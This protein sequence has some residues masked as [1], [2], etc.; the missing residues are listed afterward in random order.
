MRWLG[1]DDSRFIRATEGI[2]LLI[3]ESDLDKARAAAAV[4]GFRFRGTEMTSRAGAKLARVIKTSI[5][6]RIIWCLI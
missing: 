1:R 5:D 3:E 6:G 4:C 2:D